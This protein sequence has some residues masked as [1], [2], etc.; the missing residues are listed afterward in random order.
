MAEAGNWCLI[1]SDPGVFTELIQGMGVRGVQVEE[2][3]SLD[4]SVMEDLNPMYGLI[5]L[6]KWQK[7]EPAPDAPTPNTDATDHVFFANQVINNACAT[8][9][10]LSIL[11][12]RDDIDLGT[13]LRN[14]KEFTADFPP[15]MKGLAISNSD[16]IRSVHNSFA[17]SDPFVNEMHDPRSDKDEDLFHFIAYLPIHGALYE[18][19][20]LS[21]GPVN[22]GACHDNDWI[23][24]ANEAISSR[25]ARYGSAELHFSLMALTKDR[26]EMYEEQME[27]FDALLLSLPGDSEDRKRLN[28]ERNF[29]EHK[30]QL[31]KEKRA[32]WHRENS[33][34]K[35]NFI[36]MI[37]NMLRI[38][39]ER[40]ELEPL[41][42]DAKKKAATK[43]QR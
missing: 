23:S 22:L 4:Q 28:A 29:L 14:F 39:A 3:W 31:E 12:N 37:Y 43:Q 35:H 33:L 9:A 40:K 20:G 30:L 34:R 42:K 27:E 41:V 13:E 38:L 2:I 6:F 18:L 25:M 15:D 16:L 17:R 19:D 1:E 32:R 11:L 24:K 5:F 7:N 21:Q 10:I 26:L 8:Q 36:P